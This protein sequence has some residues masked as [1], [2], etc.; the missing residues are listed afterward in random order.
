MKLNLYQTS[1]GIVLHRQDMPQ[2]E[3]DTMYFLGTIEVAEPPKPK[4]IVTK[5]AERRNF[6]PFADGSTQ[7]RFDIP[8][9]ATNVRCYY[10]LEE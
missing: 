5:E 2:P 3:K 4:Q 6:Q 8:A 1:V 10:D 9:N 7:Y